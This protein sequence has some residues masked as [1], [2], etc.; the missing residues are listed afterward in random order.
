MDLFNTFSIICS[1]CH[2]LFIECFTKL[3]PSAVE[4]WPTAFRLEA[5]FRSSEVF[6]NPT[7]LFFAR[8]SAMAGLTGL[9]GSPERSDMI[10]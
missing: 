5:R 7:F 8:R 6:I 4:M 10:I 3:S 9:S 1:E 2:K